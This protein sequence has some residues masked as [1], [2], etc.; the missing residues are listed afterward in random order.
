MI[1]YTSD[2]FVKLSGRKNSPLL[3]AVNPTVS[4]LTPPVDVL[5]NVTFSPVLNGWFGM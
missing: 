5:L 1:T 4:G 2:V 3:A